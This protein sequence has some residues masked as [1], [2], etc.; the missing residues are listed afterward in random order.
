MIIAVTGGKGGVGKSMVALNIARELD[1]VLVEGDLTNGTLP[2]NGGPNLHEVL[3]GR[4]DAI[5]A[6]RDINGY[7][8]LPS[9]QTLEGARAVDLDRLSSLLDTVQ[10]HY[11]WVV[12]D[13]PPGLARDVG[14]EI[15][16]ADIAVIVT[17]PQRTAV[18]N[19]QETAQLASDLST[20]V[21]AVAL[22]RGDNEQHQALVN[23]LEST[24]SA[25]V[26]TIPWR[27]E[28]EQSQERHEPV[29][30]M[31][32]ESPAAAR[33]QEL[34]ERIQESQNRVG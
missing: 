21:A 4:G 3:T 12:V 14:V 10:R 33:F 18:D 13:C 25:P 22:N 26:T 32:P 16:G 29:R 17:T 28:L 5:D 20:P 31:Y 2:Q 1:A 34:A 8:L 9:G 6:V 15:A 24:M 23:D 19:A 11:G 7:S 30:N 27:R